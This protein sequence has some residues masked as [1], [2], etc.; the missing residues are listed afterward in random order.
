MTQE[1]KNVLGD[2]TRLGGFALSTMSLTSEGRNHETLERIR[3]AW[4][5]VATWGRWCDDELGTWPSRAECLRDLPQ[6]LQDSFGSEPEFEFD[7]WLS[8]LHDRSWI[9]KAARCLGEALIK[10]DLLADSLPV[11]LWTLRFVIENAGAEVL[12][13]DVWI[14]DQRASLLTP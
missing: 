9:W 6:W 3:S 7:N 8:D 10:I 1:Q 2:S 4:S 12:Y 13:D 5:S 11:S 14:D